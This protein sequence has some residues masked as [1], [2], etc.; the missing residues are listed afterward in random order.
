MSFCQQNTAYD[1]FQ[2]WNSVK[3]NNTKEYADLLRQLETKRLAKGTVC[4]MVWCYIWRDDEGGK[5]NGAEE[6]ETRE[7][8]MRGGE[9][10]ERDRTGW[11]WERKSWDWKGREENRH[12]CNVMQCN[13]KLYLDTGNHL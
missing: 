9:G 4:G 8:R 2:A 11:D 6:K 1:F 5:K 10:T 13:L 7:A 3:K 12:E